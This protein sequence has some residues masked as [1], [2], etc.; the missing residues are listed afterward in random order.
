MKI[1]KDLVKFFTREYSAS[2]LNHRYL[3]PYFKLKLKELA[4][5][6]YKEFSLKEIV[7]FFYN[8]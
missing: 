8:L 3:I 1:F 6:L 5:K 7:Q 2:G 4:I